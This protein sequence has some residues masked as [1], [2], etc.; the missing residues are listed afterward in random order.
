MALSVEEKELTA[1]MHE[2]ALQIQELKEQ[3]G[4]L[5]DNRDEIT[6][7]RIADF[8]AKRPERYTIE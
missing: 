4:N 7:Q 8:K 6:R 3:W 5:R 1:A 2:I